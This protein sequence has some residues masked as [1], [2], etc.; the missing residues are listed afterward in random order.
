MLKG[1]FS[2]V[3][4]DP[5]QRTVSKL[6]PLV[7]Q[8]NATEPTVER[9]TN[10]ELGALTRR[11][12]ARLGDGETLDDLLVEAFAAIREMAKRTVDMR[13]FDV[14]LIGGIVL[15]QGKVAE[16]RTGEGKT[17]VA[18]MPV[19]LNALTGR[20]VHL[21]TVNDYLARRDLLWMGPIYHLMGL[22]V[23]LLQSGADQPAYLYDPSYQ[24]DPYP[25]LRP[26]PRQ[27]AYA[28]DITYGTNNEFGFDYLRDNIALS[29]EQRVQRPLNYAIVDEVDNIFIDEARTPLIISGPSGE[30]VE[31]YS[32]FAA[33][34]RKLE[35][36]VHYE[37]DEKERSVFLT[38]EGLA[39]I[40]QE[41]GIENIYDEANYRYVHYMQQALKAQVLFLEGRD[42][43]R[44][45]K[46]IILIDPHTGRL[47]PNRRLSE[48]LHQA[49]EAKEA[50]PVQPRDVTSAT[51]TIQNYFRMYKKLAGMSGTAVTE[52][53][54]F[55]KIYQLD[56]VAIPTNKGVI[57]V[58]HPDMVYR[59]AEAKLRAVAREL[60]ACHCKGQPVLV[61]TTSV[62]LSERLS[63]R[64]T[65]ERLQ[66]AVIAPRLAYALQ[67][68]KL[69]REPRDALRQTLN[70]SLETMNSAVW[71]RAARDLD[72]NPNA[73]SEDN[74]DWIGQYLEVDHEPA[75]RQALERALRDGIPHEVLNA[76]EHTREAA[77]IARAGEPGAVTIATNM[78]GRGVDIKLG[79]DLPDEVIH[80]AH[81]ALR[82]RGLDPFRATSAQMDSAVAEVAPQY[83]KRRDQVLAAGG[84][85]VLGTERHEARRID[86]QLR[87]RSGRQGEPG[88]SRF[89]LSLEDDLM[90]RFGRKE[91]L[92]KLME[93]MGDDFPIEHGL[94]SKTIERAQT[95]VEGHNF[96]IRKHLLE[97]DDVL[98]RQRESI[99]GERLRILQSDDLRAEVQKM[100][101]E[102]IDE[103][104]AKWDDPEQLRLAFAGLDDVVP[105]TLPAPSGPFPG[106]VAFGGHLTAFPSF[107]IS[108]LA[109][110][111]A[112]Q[113]LESVQ[114]GLDHLAQQAAYLYGEQLGQTVSEVSRTTLEKYEERLQRYQI[115]LTEKI[116]DHMQLAE[117]RGQEADLRKLVQYLERTFPLKLTTPADRGQMNLDDL[118]DHWSQEIEIEYHRLTI[119]G[120]L[121]R[122]LVRL[123]ADL[124]LDRL[125]PAQIAEG[126]LFD[127]LKR[128][129]EMAAKQALNPE[130]RS[131]LEG[132][133]LPAEANT[134]QVVEFVS[135]FKENSQID[136]GRLDR[137]VGHVLGVELDHLILQYQ[138]AAGPDQAGLVREMERLR[139]A[140][141]EGKKSGRSADLF[142]LIRQLN[143][144]V[145]LEISDLDRFLTLAAVH[146]Y[147]KWAQRQLTEIRTNTRQ[148][149][150]RDT[151][152]TSLCEHLLAV[153]YTQK[154]A[155]DSG[156]RRLTSW[157]PLL[158]PSFL[159]QVQAESM[160]RAS[161]RDALLDSIQWAVA[162]REQSWGKQEFERW[163]NLSLT[164][165]TDPARDSL[166]RFLGEQSLEGE[167]ETL[168]EDL[169]EPLYERLRFI[170]ALRQY[171]DRRLA[172]WPHGSDLLEHLGQAL[173]AQIL[174][175]PLSEL[176]PSLQE[177]VNA[178]F[179]R[180]GLLDDAQART[181]FE[182]QP[183]QDWDEATRQ[184]VAGF[185][186][187]QF[188]EQHKNEAV[189]GLPNGAREVAVDYLQQQRRFV[190]ET[191]VQNFLVRQ[192]L[193]DLPLV[194][195]QAALDYVAR[196]RL[197]RFSR[198]KISNLDVSTRQAVI[199]SLQKAGL[200]TDETRRQEILSVPLSELDPDL[201]RGF[202]AHLARQEMGEGLR[203]LD[204]DARQHVLSALRQT[205]LLATPEQRQ[206]LLEKRLAEVDAG[207]AASIVHTLID[208]LRDQLTANTMEAL[209]ADIRQQ[210]H[211]ALEE[212]DYFVDREKAAWYE[213]NTLAQLAPDLLRGLEQ[214]LGQI[215]L[216]AL[217]QR[218][219]ADLSREEQA[220]LEEAL[221]GA[222]RITD[223]AELLR[224]KPGEALASL[225]DREREQLA[226]AL[227]RQWSV[228][229]RNQR[230][231]ALPEEERQPVW[232]FLRAQGVFADEF[233]EELFAYQRLEEFPP[234]SQMAIQDSVVRHL[235]AT[236][237]TT[238]IGELPA[239]LRGDVLA[240]LREAGL[241]M[242]AGLVRLVEESP[243][244][245][246]PDELRAAVEG[247]LGRYYLA[248][249]GS[250]PVADMPEADRQA[251]AQYLDESG[252]LLDEQKQNQV[253]DRRLID[254]EPDLFEQLVQDLK[255]QLE[256][257]I[258]E[259]AVSDLDDDMRQALRE[260]VE[261]TGYFESA[262]ERAKMLARP[263]GSLRREDLESLSQELGQAQWG[264][265][266]GRRLV[267]LP[268]QDRQAILDHLQ[269]REWFVDRQRLE[270]L[271]TQSLGA[272]DA[273]VR[274]E[275]VET[276]RREQLDQLSQKR[277]VTLR[278][279]Q[280]QA[281]L[282]FLRQAGL[283]VEENRM[284]ALRRQ[285]L[286]AV[287]R[288]LYHDLVR[289]LG[290]EK[291]AAWKPGPFRNLASDQQGGLSAYLGRR[292]MAH[293]ERRVLLNTISR[294]WID[295]LTDIE[296]LRRGIGLEAYGQRD[297]L[298]EYKRRAFELFEELGDNIRRTVARSL[299]R[300]APEPLVVQSSN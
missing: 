154:Q 84:L 272:L 46:Q 155:Y 133:T 16:M 82:A 188:I 277:L 115:L 22:S 13:P 14:Q 136:Y 12:R 295:Y 211:R 99:Y 269:S 59:S 66:M 6:Q 75:A 191:Q 252:Y 259:Q 170:L 65:A 220:A 172:D 74:L 248:Q 282:S 26:V 200:F 279:D 144:L 289:D 230:L 38:E 36:N 130:A 135:A 116:N 249:M 98:N 157:M 286:Q 223:R 92:A 80:K 164:D 114:Q 137:L 174:E 266:K 195:S 227:G 201:V 243:L 102:Q 184:E 112:E 97:Y 10:D 192:R 129:R 51:I 215:R 222:G 30:P 132:L 171:Q 35:A 37:L 58:D 146:E 91:M 56:V 162:Q 103:Y 165:L 209:P 214:Y 39:M 5:N 7:D 88:S 96:D 131:R 120:L 78:A 21:I 87:G 63:N 261:A 199:L 213:R 93:Q 283:A 229:I 293:I 232:A 62:E 126:R 276:L 255:A 3:V 224:L 179:Q 31:E 256:S 254:L 123:P 239:Q 134:S 127:E 202:G 206:D 119:E 111:F 108:F 79:G 29:L 23:G 189:E 72:V 125:R 234:D 32:L 203:G 236:L 244:P 205:D 151:S 41:T 61:G 47:M 167:Q 258:G 197:E 257:E 187:R 64:L 70:D 296:D 43:I 228:Q 139:E 143:S 67:D 15:H 33:I 183:I 77:I 271:Q 4:G 274:Q 42:Y 19:Y 50:V 95:S 287:D 240:L 219:F 140:T 18:T 76:K 299:F 1:L 109:D 45:R 242:D 221:D 177:K 238:P 161:L 113:P 142:G 251:L 122:V 294:L 20:G 105:L 270:G 210:V 176:D 268:L 55:F 273:D 147:D 149:P 265:W 186:G 73:L 49:I 156:H 275:L 284:R 40:E 8:I 57:R 27:E 106:P 253:L 260:A 153:H 107:T 160:D 208:R 225:N 54:E 216:E 280:H 121:E 233:K 104:A 166:L 9:L 193:G 17:L 292:I 168:V 100:L 175:T 90:R 207:A 247:E 297:P 24:R 159:A 262:E 163:K 101:V 181:R 241:V 89:Y 217:R 169:P 44:Q 194:T 69:E 288:E 118:Q 285:S 291:V 264:Q 11:F 86:N 226:K 185:W 235:E 110:Q 138:Q 212:Q 290:Y 180:N 198:R 231:P 60:L 52:S 145:H 245:E 246:L 148:N 48:G 204:D 124:A 267:E 34:A 263:L 68:A 117:D 25:G 278:P 158:P 150:L 71:R 190:D 94:V 298:V 128:V 237:A 152:W 250:D 178:L 196:T 281:A 300:R 141:I 81:Q 182:Q 85:H 28:A 53:E 83:A 2:K 173:E 218:P